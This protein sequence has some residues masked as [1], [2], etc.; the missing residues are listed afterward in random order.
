MP[1]QPQN[2]SSE[3]A[4]SVAELVATMPL[5]QAAQVYDFVRF[6]LSQREHRSVVDDNTWLN[7]SE[8]QMLAEDAKW[9]SSP[10]DGST[11]LDMLKAAA[12]KEIDA[13]STKP[14]FDAKGEF[15]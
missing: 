7:D 6:L 3:Y 4:Q 11:Q 8:E 12:R 13:E 9:E 15:M 1:K 10:T 5:E 2:Q 14:M